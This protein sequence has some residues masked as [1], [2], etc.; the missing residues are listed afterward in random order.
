MLELRK[1]GKS[2]HVDFVAGEIRI[3]G[4]L[5]TKNQDAAR[6]IVHKLGV[7]ISE[8]KE[9]TLWLELKAVLPAA[10]FERFADY[11]GFREKAIPTWEELRAVYEI[12]ATQRIALGKLQQSTY[13]RY[14]VTIREFD[15]F[16]AEHR[17]RFLE[18]I[19]KPLVEA[20]K[21]W[22]KARIESHKFSRGGTGLVLDAAILHRVFALAVENEMIVKNPVKMEGRPGKTQMAERSLSPGINWQS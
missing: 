14:A 9:S 6:R 11:A 18:H 21:V 17:I 19:T 13:D 5:G 22:R 16:L 1:R 7:A 20:F 4:A 15:Q 10:T 3:R 8:G 12:H 2:H